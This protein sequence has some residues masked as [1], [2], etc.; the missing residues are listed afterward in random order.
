M[1]ERNDLLRAHMV[2]DEII[3][4]ISNYYPNIHQRYV[5]KRMKACVAGGFTKV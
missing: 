2:H 1:T 4:N 3:Q 5:G